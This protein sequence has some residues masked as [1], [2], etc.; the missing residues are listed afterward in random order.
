[1]R[2]DKYYSSMKYFGSGGEVCLLRTD[3]KL[4]RRMR[5]DFKLSPAKRLWFCGYKTKFDALL[6]AAHMCRKSGEDMDW[7]LP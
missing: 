7:R 1:M 3:K 4:G 6:A 2:K 5:W